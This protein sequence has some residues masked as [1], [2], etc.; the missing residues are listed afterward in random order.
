MVLF[1]MKEYDS[2]K[3]TIGKNKGIIREKYLNEV[4]KDL[5]SLMCDAFKKLMY[6]L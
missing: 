5:E 6:K 4:D 3:M 2:W 1:I